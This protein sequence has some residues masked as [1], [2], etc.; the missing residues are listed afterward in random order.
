MNR[1]LNYIYDPL[2]GWC[3]GA[4]PLLDAARCIDDLEIALNAGGLWPEPTRL[5]EDTRRYIQ[6]ADARIAATSGQ[7][8]GDAYLSELLMDPQMVLESKPPIAAI[9]AS[10]SL[11]AGKDYEM[12]RAIQKAHYVHGQHVVKSEVLANL[13]AGIGL[14][15]NEFADAMMRAPIDAHIDET[16]RL[17]SQVGA[18]GFPTFVLEI[19]GQ[20]LVVPHAQFAGNPAGFAEWLVGVV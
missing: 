1:R 11:S 15:R 8:F 16:R 14:G 4:A 9:L 12:L 5:P 7:T 2:C 13:A 20:R 10:N 6:Q 3:Y 19:D 18:S 17:M